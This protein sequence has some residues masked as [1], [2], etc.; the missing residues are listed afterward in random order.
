MQVN[1]HLQHIE[2]DKSQIN[3]SV[4]DKEKEKSLKISF[5]MQVYRKDLKNFNLKITVV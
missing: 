4:R 3:N 5:K 2:K 1:S